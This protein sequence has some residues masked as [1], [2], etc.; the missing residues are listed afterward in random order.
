MHLLTPDGKDASL[1][2]KLAY[3]DY[4]EDTKVLLNGV[5]YAVSVPQLIN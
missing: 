1:Y 2:A 4:R 5:C 3:S